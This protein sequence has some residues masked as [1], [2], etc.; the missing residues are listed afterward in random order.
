MEIISVESALSY[1]AVKNP[2]MFYSMQPLK[3]M[4]HPLLNLKLS[5]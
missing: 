5:F 4:I 2:L 1:S 3:A